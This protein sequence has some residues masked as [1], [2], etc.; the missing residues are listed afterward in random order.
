M[1]TDHL[2]QC[3]SPRTKLPQ[4]QGDDL[5]SCQAT[6]RQASCEAKSSGTVFAVSPSFSS[7]SPLKIHPDSQ[8]WQTFDV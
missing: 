6:S 1:K 4:T 3:H 2:P 5:A 8:L 7:L